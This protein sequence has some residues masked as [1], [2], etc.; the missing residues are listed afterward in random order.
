MLRILPFLVLLSLITKTRAQ[1]GYSA[2]IRTN[3]DYCVGSS[4]SVN[5]QHTL[6]RIIWYKD[7]QPIDSAL[8]DQRLASTPKAIQIPGVWPVGD[9]VSDEAG[10]LYMFDGPRNRVI[11]YNPAGGGVTNMGSFPGDKGDA[12]RLFVDHQG[13]IYASASNSK[14]VYKLSPGA[15][16]AT[17][18]ATGKPSNYSDYGTGLYVDC[19]GNVYVADDLQAIIS[20]WA[21]GATSGVTIAGGNGLG[22]AANQLFFMQQIS[23][24]TSGNLIILEGSRLA[25]WP[26]GAK[27]GIPLIDV[28]QWQSTTGAND[29]WVDGKD[30][31]YFIVWMSPQTNSYTNIAK[32]PSGLDS[33]QIIGSIPQP[34]P[35]SDPPQLTVDDKGNIFA[36]LGSD[37]TLYEFK[38]TSSIDLDFTPTTTGEYYAV[39]TDIRGYASTTNKI[40]INTPSSGTPGISISATAT[41][42]AVCTPITFTAV[43]VNPGIDPAYQWM[44][45]G[46]NAGNGGLTYSGNLFADSDQVYCIMTAQA[47]CQGTVVDTS[48]IIL[49]SIDPHGTASVRIS[50]PKD[51]ICAGDSVLFTAVVTNGSNS[52][53]F[54]WLLNGQP[55]GDET[56]TYGGSN[57]QKNDVITC[58]ITSDDV[59]GLAKSNSIAL[60]VSTPPVIGSG[61]IITILSGHSETLEPAITGDANTFLWTPGAGL[62]DSTIE[63][64]VASPDSNTLY[65]LKVTAA[66]GCSASGTILVNVYTPLSIPNGFTPNGDGHN[67]LFYVLGGPINSRVEE[68]A[69]FDRYGVQVFGVHNVAPGDRNFAW[70]GTFR[71]APAQPGTYVYIVVMKYADGQRQVYKGTVILIR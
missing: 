48:N 21:P 32:W 64:P 42:T 23:R 67:D 15:T 49:L 36:I 66:G 41:S 65:T 12:N 46:V 58:L 18:V 51:S 26:E 27:T 25:K 24:D 35:G 29:L 9:L 34:K 2:T 45:S 10:N 33:P 4:L 14:L 60:T 13:N 61:Q 70:N 8:A 28:A 56:G 57:F 71:G 11:R 44:V 59:C 17:V 30:T 40:I 43:P 54:Q 16:E 39:V 62:S 68:F 37:S 50:T 38:R 47:G 19:G 31:C 52:P 1:C 5:T 7:G 6:E 55:T 69:V 3:K 22:Y 20:K 63:N 53:V